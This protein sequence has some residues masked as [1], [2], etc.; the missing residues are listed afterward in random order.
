MDCVI[1]GSGGM[2][3][4]PARMTTSLLLRREGRLI[5]FDAGE[6][7]Q[8]SLKRCGFGI[9]NLDVVAISHMHADHVLGLP[10]I[11]MFR[12]QCEE[13]GPLTIIGP[14]GIEQFVRHTIED[15]H[16]H[17]GYD[18]VFV[19]WNVQARPAAW[20]WHGHRLIW[21]PLEHSTFC[22]GYRLEE[23]ARPGRFDPAAATALGVPPGPLCGQL[24]EGRA[25]TAPDGRTIVPAAVMGPP[26]RGRIVVF[27]TDTMPCAGLERLCA[28]A[29]F[30]FIEGM[31]TNRHEA[32]ALR[33][34]HMTA[35]QA[36][37]AA[38]SAGAHE[39]VLV[40]VSPRY[41]RDDDETLAQEAQEFFPTARVGND[42]DVYS[43]PLPD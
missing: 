20:D 38:A 7:I 13:P 2:M 32:E 29:D 26:R 28:G 8:L 15:L 16:Y 33:K 18:L 43:V 12:A 14:P 19:E 3:P 22:L 31:F 42:L 17:L 6:G 27:A 41:T 1:L 37:R 9:K 39:L 30:A 36:A 35:A 4:M 24:Q 40:H 10:G 5:M 25:V 23:A 21:E 34:K 11:M